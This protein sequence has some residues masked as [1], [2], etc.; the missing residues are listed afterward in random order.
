MRQAGIIAAAGLYC[1]D[2]HIERLKDDHENAKAMARIIN[3]MKSPNVFINTEELDT[4]IIMLNVHGFNVPEFCRR[5]SS[6]DENEKSSVG[7]LVS[8]R[9]FPWSDTKTRLVLHLDITSEMAE[10]AARKVCYVTE[11]MKR[12]VLNM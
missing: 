7:S 5:L 6:V 1:L 10:K 3:S 9:C 8:L 4:N 11:G 12:S 2:N